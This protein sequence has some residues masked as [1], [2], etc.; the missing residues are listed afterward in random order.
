MNGK[1]HSDKNYR[2][3]LQKHRYYCCLIKSNLTFIMAVLVF[4]PW[5]IRILA[6]P[7]GPEADVWHPYGEWWISPRKWTYLCSSCRRPPYGMGNSGRCRLD[8]L[9]I[10]PQHSGTVLP[11]KLQ[12]QWNKWRL[13]TE[14]FYS[15]INTG[16][17]FVVISPQHYYQFSWRLAL[18]TYAIFSYCE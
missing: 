14:I 1:C 15:F 3:C 7:P 18:L 10:R 4:A 8:S 16:V 17:I 2:V 13:S 5:Q 9:Y 11:H 6:L 12:R